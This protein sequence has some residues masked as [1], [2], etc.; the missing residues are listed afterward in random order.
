[1]DNIDKDLL[2]ERI[3]RLFMKNGIGYAKDIAKGCSIS[4]LTLMK[5][6]NKGAKIHFSTLTMLRMFCDQVERDEKQTNK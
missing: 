3:G 1:M 5:F 2:R 4:R 6:F